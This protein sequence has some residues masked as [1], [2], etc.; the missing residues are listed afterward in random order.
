MA[1]NR[2]VDVERFEVVKDFTTSNG[3]T[4]YLKGS[5]GVA[6]IGSSG[7]VLCKIGSE[8]VLLPVE[9]YRELTGQTGFTTIPTH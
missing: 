5:E 6:L 8:T 2:I 7:P 3:P 1:K 9:D 4:V